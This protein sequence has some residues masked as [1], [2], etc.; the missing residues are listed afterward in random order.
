M[1]FRS[2]EE[3]LLKH[4]RAGDAVALYGFRCGI[5]DGVDLRGASQDEVRE[6]FFRGVSAEAISRAFVSESSSTSSL[7]FFPEATAALKSETLSVGIAN[8]WFLPLCV[9]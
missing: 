3:R 5:Y 8:E 2:V 1:L 9:Y 7:S 6:L 4:R